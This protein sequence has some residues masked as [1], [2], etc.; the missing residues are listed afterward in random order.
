MVRGLG[1]LD[2]IRQPWATLAAL[3]WVCAG[4]F[5][6]GSPLW[7]WWIYLILSATAIPFVLGSAARSRLAAFSM[8]VA[9]MLG[10]AFWDMTAGARPFGPMQVS[11]LIAIAGLA[12][13]A[14]RYRRE[15]EPS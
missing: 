5:L 10:G 4:A 2:R 3:F 6:Q 11:A 12:A 14:G 13:L 7:V 1:G 9:V 8:G 15:Q